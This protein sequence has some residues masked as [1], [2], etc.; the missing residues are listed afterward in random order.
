MNHEQREQIRKEVAELRSLVS[1]A[2]NT[3]ADALDEI[4]TITEF[5]T[6]TPEQIR[7]GVKAICDRSR[8]LLGLERGG[9]GR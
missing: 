2:Y 7:D 3:F 8:K 9:G 5:E 4:Q 6:A 1:T